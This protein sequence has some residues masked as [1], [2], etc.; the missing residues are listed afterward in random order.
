MNLDHLLIP[1]AR[2]SLTRH[3][4]RVA[5]ELKLRLHLQI[6]HFRW[7]RRQDFFDRLAY[8][9]N[10]KESVEGKRSGLRS[11]EQTLPAGDRNQGAGSPRRYYNTPQ[12]R[13]FL[14]PVQ[15]KKEDFI[16]GAFGS[17]MTPDHNGYGRI[18]EAPMAIG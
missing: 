13:F 14:S 5:D 1:G 18:R 6:L 11:L 12:N 17:L 2:W 7:T 9:P 3:A 4:S 8:D 15:I 10:V 16:S